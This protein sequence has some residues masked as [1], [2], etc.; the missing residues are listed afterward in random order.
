[1]FP[2]LFLLASSSFQ[3]DEPAP[4]ETPVR[5]ELFRSP[6]Y[7][8][9]ICE[10]TMRA[11]V[12]ASDPSLRGTVTF[13]VPGDYSGQSVIAFRV[14]SEPPT[15]LKSWIWTPR[16]DGFNNVIRATVAPGR[17]EVSIS[18]TALVAVSGFGIPRTQKRNYEQWLAPSA[19]IQ[20]ADPQISELDKRLKA[21]APARSD[22]AG[23]VVQWVAK[24]H[25]REEPAGPEN[26]LRALAVGGDSLG[27]SEL[28]AAL[29]RH[30]G[31]GARV[32]AVA[33]MWAEGS[34][35]EHWL[36]EYASDDNCWEMLEPTVGI[37]HPVR[38]SVIVL[39]I[40]AVADEA[41]A[42][43]ASPALRPDAPRMS[44]PE[45]S[46]NLRWAPHPQSEKS[47]ELRIIRTFPRQSGARLMLAAQR[48]HVQVVKSAEAGR[49]E[50]IEPGLLD[51]ILEK[52]PINLALYLDGQPTF[53]G[54][55]P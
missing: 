5:A 41:A 29:L 35:A 13:P 50:W 46:S 47:A 44:I 55:K 9:R 38:N 33:P 19:E 4:K 48:R 7:G 20:S 8:P 34:D 12:V 53:P 26:A 10:F 14:Q 18:Y 21:N 6:T 16:D 30:A 54:G 52:G 45:I 23:L 43:G 15:A 27:R 37:Q 28:C 42:P 24:N 32:L 3:L 36:T 49:A 22:F 40:S 25:L 39:S 1:M 11:R 17:Q 31:I 51:R 2:A